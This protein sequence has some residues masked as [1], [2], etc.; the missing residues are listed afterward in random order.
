MHF[1][2]MPRGYDNGMSQKQQC[3]NMSMKSGM[4]DLAESARFRGFLGNMNNSI[5]NSFMS[6][7]WGSG[8]GGGWGGGFTSF[9]SMRPFYGGGWSSNFFGGGGGCSC[10]FNN[11]W[12]G[13]SCSFG[14]N[15]GGNSAANIGLKWLENQVHANSHKPINLNTSLLG[16]REAVGT[17]FGIANDA[18]NGTFNLTTNTVNGAYNT[19]NSTVDGTNTFLFGKQQ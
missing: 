1:A 11:N 10:A 9:G 8:W 7:N 13:S 5:Y 4:A 16:L 19:V 17:V 2:Y 15:F 18:V 6:G 12:G 14:N 3:W